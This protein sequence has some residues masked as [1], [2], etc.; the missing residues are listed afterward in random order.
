MT[1]DDMS[2]SRAWP[3]NLGMLLAQGTVPGRNWDS[4][5]LR[6]LHKLRRKGRTN[7]RM[8]MGIGREHASVL[9]E[10]FT[11]HTTHPNRAGAGA[12]GR[13]LH[14]SQKAGKRGNGSSKVIS[15]PSRR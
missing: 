8:V 1:T 10:G 4:Y 12:E 6:I 2:S 15:I 14:V 7:P 9:L 5:L 13:D 3:R 11:A